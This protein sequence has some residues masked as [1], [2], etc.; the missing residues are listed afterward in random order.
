MWKFFFCL[1][2]IPESYWH[3]IRILTLPTLCC[4]CACIL[5]VCMYLCTY[6]CMYLCIYVSIY[7]GIYMY[8]YVSTFT[9]PRCNLHNPYIYMYDYNWLKTFH[10]TT[11]RWTTFVAEIC[12]CV[13]HIVNIIPPNTHCCVWRYTH[14]PYSWIYS[15]KYLCYNCTTLTLISMFARACHWPISGT[16]KCT[17]HADTAFLTCL[18]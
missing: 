18:F 1:S 10:C 15:F 7:L 12:S 17:E 9:S 5:Y 2:S 11:W 3:N 16:T 6:L 8:L 14:I 4:M 13:L